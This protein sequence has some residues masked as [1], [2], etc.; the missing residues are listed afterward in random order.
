L[1]DRSVIFN[2]RSE[3]DFIASS[4]EIFRFQYEHNS[5]YRQWCQALKV[6]P[7]KVN[8]LANIPFLPIE[9]FKSQKVI[10]TP[11][12]E[13]TRIF[14]SSVT[15][16]Q[17][18]SKHYV[19]DIS[20]YEESFLKGFRL[21]YG[22]PSDYVFLCLLPGYLERSDS[23]LVYMFNK[24]M[25]ISNKKENGSFLNAEK[26]LLERIDGIKTQSKKCILIGVSYALL[27]LCGKVNLSDNF[28]V[29]ETGGMKGKREEM[30]K[31]AL[32]AEL[33]K[34][35]G[36]KT[37][38]SEYGMT[39]LLSQA[40]SKGEGIYNSPPWLKFLIRD[41][42]DPLQILKN[43]KTGGLN[44]IDLANINSCSFIATKDLGRISEKG[45]EIMGRFDESDIRGCN[46]M[47][48]E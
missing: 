6:G 21:F 26:E 47:L 5:V 37:V 11:E 16:K 23:S 10:S 22:E 7:D 48:S 17:A 32:H 44:I 38:H 20:V 18:P 43:E 35:L 29:M 13:K 15:T 1:P 9:F 2:I 27:D 3:D 28:I 31:E 25:E 30:T 14:L 34:G 12:N 33:K 24:L 45:L 40:Y 4:L 36:I 19:N 41:V 42:N 39:E 8:S 46:L